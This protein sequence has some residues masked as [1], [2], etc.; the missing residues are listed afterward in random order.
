MAD[1][2]TPRLRTKYDAEIAKA[3]KADDMKAFA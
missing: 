3:M 1:T 2:Y